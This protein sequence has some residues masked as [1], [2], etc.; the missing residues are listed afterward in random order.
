M[1]KETTD[2]PRVGDGTPGPGRPKGSLNKTTKAAKEAIAI[3]AE[4]LGGSDRLVAWAKEDQKNEHA[5]WTTIYPKLIPIDVKASGALS[6]NVTRE[7]IG[8]KD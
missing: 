6:L 8:R 7:F 4:E 1:D 3:A 5:F 2:N